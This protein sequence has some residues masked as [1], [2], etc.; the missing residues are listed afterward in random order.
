[1]GAV[2]ATDQRDAIEKATK[3]FNLDP[4][5]PCSGGIQWLATVV[6]HS[7]HATLKARTNAVA[8]LRA[9]VYPGVYP[10]AFLALS[11]SG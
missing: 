8:A 6:S 10:G 1:V 4:A 3:E 2:E 9:R 11:I 5:N 7:Q